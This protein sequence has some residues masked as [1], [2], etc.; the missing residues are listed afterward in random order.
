MEKRYDYTKGEKAVQKLWQSL[1]IHDYQPNSTKPMY[2]IDTP[3]PTVSGALHIGHIFS[4]TQAEIIARYKRMRGYNLF[5]PFGFDDNGLPTERLVERDHKIRADQL[6]QEDFT[7]LCLKT[8]AQYENEFKTLWESLGFSCDWS[9]QYE[10]ISPATQRIA[11]RSFIELYQKGLAYRKSAPVLWCPHCQTSIAQADVDSQDKTTQFITLKFELGGPIKSTPIPTEK[12]ILLIATT[13]PEMLYGCVAIFVHPNDE[14]Y[15]L[16]GGRFATVPIYG[17]QVPIL[18]DEA[19]AMDKG[20]GAVMC[21]TFGDSA[22]L[23]WYDS[24]DLSY[25]E[26]LMPDGRLNPTIPII[27]GLNVAK[28]RETI[29]EELYNQDL[30]ADGQMVEH[31][32]SVHERCGKAI[33]ILPSPQWY[34]DL[35]NHKEAF[36]TAGDAINWHPAYMKTRYMHWV[37]NLKWD[38]CISRQRFFGTPFPVWYCKDCGAIHIADGADYDLPINPKTSKP[39]HPCH[40]GS[41]DFEA[42][43]AIMDTWMTSSVTPQINQKWGEVDQRTELT[44]PM[45]LRTQAHEIIRTWAFYTIAKSHFHCGQIPWKDIMISGFVLAK[46]GEKISKSKDN[47]TQ[48]PKALIEAHSADAVR[49]WTAGNKLGTDTY[50]DPSELQNAKRLMTKLW[51][52]ARFIFAQLADFTPNF[53]TISDFRL[54]TENKTSLGTE[55]NL[56]EKKLPIDMWL[57]ER[58]YEVLEQMSGALDGF[59]MGAARQAMDD[60]FWSDLCDDYLEFAKERLY[61]PEKHGYWQQE[62]GQNALYIAFL[63]I[64]KGYA[65]YM[66]HLTEALYQEFYA[67][68]EPLPSLHLHQ[69]SIEDCKTGKGETAGKQGI[70][71]KQG[72]ATKQELEALMTF[73]TS[74]KGILTDARRYKSEN[75]LSMK[76]EM[77]A[78]VIDKAGIRGDWLQLTLAD[79]LACTHAQELTIMG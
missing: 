14:R 11:Q 16:L 47:S 49:Y 21:C 31:S 74:I 7:A 46:K 29:I 36:I 56:E 77:P 37:Q 8:T 13:R 15:Q 3:P 35:L 52:A 65:I 5:Y 20:T 79:L 71:G 25:R 48:S 32:Y 22:D 1:K 78:I 75:G 34:I 50:F 2:S 39:K 18:G 54:T 66:P 41:N 33:E 55:T 68:L 4:Y 63:N 26:T 70:A 10:T 30:I 23:T 43:S 60:F 76:A 42:E 64:L 38:W 61:Q 58:S 19:V 73:G 27:G 62:S 40:C 69:W 9:L 67:A 24:H 59:E 12:E 53:E 28:A 51:S 17:H 72:T 57:V 6:S 45:G 44:L